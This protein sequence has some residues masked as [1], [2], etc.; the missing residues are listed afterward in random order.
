MSGLLVYHYATKGKVQRA[1]ERQELEPSAP[2]NTQVP[3][4][5][6]EI[7][8]RQFPFTVSR[9]NIFCLLEPTPEGWK[10]Y[11]LL[12]LLLENATGRDHLLELAVSDEGLLIRDHG[13]HSPKAYGMLPQEWSRREMRDSRPD[14]REAFY[15]STVLLRDYPGGFACPEILVPFPVPISQVRIVSIS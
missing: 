11:G 6:F 10:G 3:A 1:F 8:S 15:R 7:Y 14:L 5:E 13:L 4:D 12:E 9:L 2:F